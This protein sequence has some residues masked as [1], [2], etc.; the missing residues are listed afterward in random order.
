M[1]VRTAGRRQLGNASIFRSIN[2]LKKVPQ[3]T[4]Q[5]LLARHRSNEHKSLRR[6]RFFPDFS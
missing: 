4:Y 5:N 1:G 6:Q 3:G 2:A